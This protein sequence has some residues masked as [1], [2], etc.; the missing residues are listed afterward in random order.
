MRAVICQHTA[1]Q[2]KILPSCSCFL[3]RL[4]SQ[5]N[6]RTL[7]WVP[8]LPDAA[9][10]GMY[11]KPNQ[12]IF[13]S[14]DNTKHTSLLQKSRNCSS[15]QHPHCEANLEKVQV[16]KWED[17]GGCTI[18]NA[19]RLTHLVALP[20][21]VK[22]H[23]PT[24]ETQS[25]GQILSRVKCSQHHLFHL[26]LLVQTHRGTDRHFCCSWYP[27]RASHGW[28]LLLCSTVRSKLLAMHK[29]PGSGMSKVTL[30]QHIPKTKGYVLEEGCRF[31]SIA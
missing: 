29:P 11:S 22:T 10:V 17:G 1:G 14:R 28:H 19:P 6:T 16:S 15:R 3:L 9:Q 21:Q 12:P 8:P 23:S 26:D 27:P 20:R 24:A 30:C 4:Q 25:E 7:I 18:S 5:W 31:A 2:K 13:T